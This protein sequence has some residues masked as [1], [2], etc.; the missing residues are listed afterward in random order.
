[1]DGPKPAPAAEGKRTRTA[2]EI[3]LKNCKE[4]FLA[5]EEEQHPGERDALLEE[6]QLN[7]QRTLAQLGQQADAFLEARAHLYMGR[8]LLEKA[9]LCANGEQREPFLRPM[10]DHVEI[11]FDLGC[12][13]EEMVNGLAVAERAC[14]LM[15][16]ARDASQGL[17]RQAFTARLNGRKRELERMHADYLNRRK[18]AADRM[19]TALALNADAKDISNSALKEQALRSALDSA[20]TA[21]ALSAATGFGEVQDLARSTLAEIEAALESMGLQSG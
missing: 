16:S 9:A 3:R 4:L 7:C 18:D 12:S 2:I 11:A 6:I 14:E 8:C 21:L 15:E 1:M 17:L 10:S 19:Q 13:L 5:F 20:R